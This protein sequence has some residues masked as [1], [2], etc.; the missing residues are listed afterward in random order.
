VAELG[1]LTG[2]ILL[3]PQRMSTVK[4]RARSL[5]RTPRS[6]NGAEG[7]GLGP[8]RQWKTGTPALYRSTKRTPA[9]VFLSAPQPPSPLHRLYTD[10]CGF[11][12]AASRPSGAES[13]DTV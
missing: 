12:L 13:T 7:A 5:F 11:A 8:E 2:R 4:I 6:R 3:S 1:N 10:I 9:A